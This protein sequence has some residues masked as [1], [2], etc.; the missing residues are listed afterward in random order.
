MILNILI[1]LGIVILFVM[2]ISNKE[3]YK[4]KVVQQK[5]C[6]CGKTKSSFGACDGS[7]NENR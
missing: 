7:H 1:V 3:S 5:P 4:T 2:F 6:G